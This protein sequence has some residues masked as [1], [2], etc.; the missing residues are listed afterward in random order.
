MKKTIIKMMAVLA[1]LACIFIFAACDQSESPKPTKE[2][3]L[4]PVTV[5]T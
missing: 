1:I 3:K 5:F 4:Y 2:P